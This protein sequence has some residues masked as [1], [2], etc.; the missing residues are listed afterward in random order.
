MNKEKRLGVIKITR[1]LIKL[2]PSK[3][4]RIWGL[5]DFVP[6]SIEHDFKSDTILYKGIGKYFARVPEGGVFPYY[7]LEDI[8][9]IVRRALIEEEEDKPIKYRGTLKFDHETRIVEGEL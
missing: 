7:S 3:V 6:T 5:I 1:E 8:E 2:N 4:L 9:D